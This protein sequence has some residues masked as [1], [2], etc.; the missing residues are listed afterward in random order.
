MLKTP[1]EL[2]L[3]LARGI[4]ARRIAQGW[5]QREASERSG[6]P[7][8]T[9]RR[10]E[11]EGEGSTRHLIQAAVA[12]RCEDNLALLFPA[13]AAATMDELLEWQASAAPPKPRQRTARRR[14][15]P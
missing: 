15:P 7:H 1:P 14:S 3:E 4:R 6:V 11:I 5:S 2:L 12:L 10:L 13:P 8:R 9:W